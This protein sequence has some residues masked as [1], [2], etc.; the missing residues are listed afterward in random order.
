MP[1]RLPWSLRGLI[2]STSAAVATIVLATSVSAIQ[3]FPDPFGG[4]GVFTDIRSGS[5][6]DDI[7]DAFFLRE[8]GTLEIEMFLDDADFIETHVC[9]SASPYTQRIPPGQCQ[10]Q[11]SGPGAHSYDIPLPPTTFPLGNEPF[12]DPLASFCVQVHIKYTTVLA[13][14]SAGGG[15]AFA[16]WQAGQ[17]FYGNLCF[18]DVPEPLPPD[19]GTAIV[20]KV[21]ELV[22]SDI[23]FTVT[24]TNPTT[25]IATDVVVIEALPPKLAPWT[26]PPACT[27]DVVDFIARC[28]IGDLAGGASVV[29]DFSASPPPEVCGAFSNYA[30]TTVGSPVVRSADL[31]IVDVPCPPDPPPDP[32][33]LMSKVPSSTLVTAPGTVSF[34]V[35]FEN[36]G[37]GTATNVTFTDEL[38]PEFE[39]SL[40]SGENVCSIE[41]TTLTCFAETVP[42]GVFEVLEIIAIV[43]D[44]D[45]GTYDNTATVTFE[46]GPEPGSVTA[47]AP[48]VEITGCPAASGAPSA[49]PSEA[50]SGSTAPTEDAGT[51]VGGDAGAGSELPDTRA[52][53]VRT[54][55]AALSLTAMFLAG[56]VIV[57]RT[58]LTQGRR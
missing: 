23:V 24:A 15:S 42:D 19:E 14:T 27:L 3:T 41:S 36:A 22:G 7:G 33:I 35:T 1:A 50:A 46:G 51:D 29:L 49:A 34:F 16:G 18:P 47:I 56:V 43:D 9:V 12:T 55:A 13:R 25:E 53:P 11:K 38:S 2:G 20:T 37:P 21:G 17:P 58:H 48:S 40:G 8:G 39:W 32:Q 4:E 30:L 44:T 26:V 57:V 28:E 31:V 10:F 5:N 45:C 52:E 54:P 6:G